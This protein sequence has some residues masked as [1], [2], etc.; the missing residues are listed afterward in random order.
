MQWSRGQSQRL[1]QHSCRNRRAAHAAQ[2]LLQG[3]ILAARPY[4]GGAGLAASPTRRKQGPALSL[5]QAQL[6]HQGAGHG[7]VAPSFGGGCGGGPA[8]GGECQQAGL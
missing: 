1:H 8:A 5:T 6:V 4:R 7:Q 2:Q 3:A